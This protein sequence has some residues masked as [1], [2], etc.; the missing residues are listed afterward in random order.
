MV[1]RGKT[2]VFIVRDPHDPLKGWGWVDVDEDVVKRFG[3]STKQ[4]QG[5]FLSGEEHKKLRAEGRRC[6]QFIRP[7]SRGKAGGKKF[8]VNTNGEFINL[9]VQKSLAIE[10]VGAWIRT[11]ASPDAKIRFFSI[12]YAKLTIEMPTK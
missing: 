1:R 9:S 11:W 8:V 3:I 2:T 12:C 7:P 5:I 6:P 10:A 4:P